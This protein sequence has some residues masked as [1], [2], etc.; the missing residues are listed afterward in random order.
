MAKIWIKKEVQESL[1]ET[2]DAL[3]DARYFT[4]LD[5][6]NGYWQVS[7]KVEDKKKTAFVT[8]H[9]HWEFNV[10]PFGLTG[11]PPAFQCLM[12]LVLHWTNCLV[13]LD[14]II[15]FGRTFDEHL[16]RLREVLLRL[17]DAGLTLKLKKCHNRAKLQF[18]FLDTWFLMVKSGPTQKR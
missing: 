2:L 18:V 12:D 15:V 6:Q 9:G 7:V 1:Y 10:L 11:A 4:T 3:S 14:D 8:H 5:L 13:Y 17:R 16:E